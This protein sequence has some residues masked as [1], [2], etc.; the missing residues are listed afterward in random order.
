MKDRNY[1]LNG[2]DGYYNFVKKFKTKSE[3]PLEAIKNKAKDL[4]ENHAEIV[5]VEDRGIIVKIARLD[6]EG[7]I[8]E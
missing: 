5:T 1:T 4:L 2:Y 6:T 7:G 3:N 8:H